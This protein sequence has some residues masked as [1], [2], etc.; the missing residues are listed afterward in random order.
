MPTFVIEHLEPEVYEWCKLEYAHISTFVG[1]ENLLFTNTKSSE[2]KNLGKIE[3]KS[4]KELKLAKACILDPEAK[5]TL[6]PEL[7]KKYEYFI[8]GG[9]LGDEPPKAR[10]KQELTKH[11]PYPAYN[12]GKDQMSTDTAVIVTKMIIDGKKL[13]ELEFAQ[14]IE[15]EINENESVYLPYKY[16]IVDDKVLL[17]PGLINMLKKQNTF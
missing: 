5:E 7:A 12:L 10:T 3:P 13:S 6:T 16:L 15:V 9:I 4:I 8:F 1:K 14:G 2:L 11:M 17:A